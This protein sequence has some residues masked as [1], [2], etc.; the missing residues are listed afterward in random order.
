MAEAEDLKSSQCGFESHREYVYIYTI[1]CDFPDCDRTED[2]EPEANWD[3]ALMHPNGW[4]Y[5]AGMYEALCPRHN[6][7]RFL[8]PVPTP[9][10][11]N[12]LSDLLKNVYGKI[13]EDQLAPLNKVFVISTPSDVITFPRVGKDVDDSNL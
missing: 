2:T 3:S 4:G 6:Y 5:L 7:T 9:Y 1:A 13:I 8:Q 10:D 11:N 12:P